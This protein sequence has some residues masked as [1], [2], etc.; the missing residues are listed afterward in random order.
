VRA[1]AFRLAEPA[2]VFVSTG[3]VHHFRGDELPQL[4][5]EQARSDALA[6]V[7]LDIRPTWAAAIGAFI[8]HQA[9]MRVA[10]A[11]HDGYLSAVRAHPTP[12]LVA[13]MR[14]GAPEHWHAMLDDD[15]PL[16]PILSI[17]H[18]AISLRPALAEPFL[19]AAPPALRARLAPCS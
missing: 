12:A 4:F 8:F 10:L 19:E 13:A 3:V 2:T 16:L 5:R 9:R 15:A 14:A 6:M 1:N 18:A 7:H 17:M 11:R